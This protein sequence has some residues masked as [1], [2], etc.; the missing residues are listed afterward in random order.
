MLNDDL[1][2]QTRRHFFAQCPIGVGAM[3]LWSLLAD[4]SHAAS[5]N[6][7]APKKPHFPAKAKR[8]I[9]LFMAGGPSQL[10]LFDYKPALA[11]LDG[12][13]IPESYI[14]GKRFA[15][16]DSSHRTTLL[17]GKRPFK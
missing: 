12:K 13:P 1:R 14:K 17:A 3:G 2:R 5:D 4:D 11:K 16:M 8:I 7:L 15:F 9:F 10:E 6:P